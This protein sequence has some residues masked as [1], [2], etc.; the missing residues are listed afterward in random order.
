MLSQGPP[1]LRVVLLRDIFPSPNEINDMLETLSPDAIDMSLAVV[2]SLIPPTSTLT[3]KTY[4]L[5]TFDSRGFSP[6]ARVVGALLQVL[7]ED[8]TVA[9]QNFWAVHHF[10]ALSIYAQDFQSMPSAQS[11]AFEL[12]ALTV[13]LGDIITKVQQVVTYLLTS[14]GDDG[15]RVS[16]L[17]AVMNDKS[18]EE[19]GA[20]PRFLVD[21]VKRSQRQDALRESRILRYVLQHIL[22]EADK[23]EAD[24][25]ITLARKIERKG[26]CFSLPVP[27]YSRSLL[28]SSE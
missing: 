5:Q 25:W 18:A 10:L 27:V 11:P 19:L 26:L 15:W 14:S 2:D 13:R 22:D 17:N 3:R 24:L 8:R 28:C 7:V 4:A 6:Y 1:G 23:A 21:T 9:K 16:A 20:L 12:T